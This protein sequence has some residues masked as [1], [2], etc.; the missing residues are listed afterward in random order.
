MTLDEN[1]PPKAE[2]LLSQVEL[3]PTDPPQAE[4]VGILWVLFLPCLLKMSLLAM[5]RM[6]TQFQKDTPLLCGGE[7]HLKIMKFSKISLGVCR[8]LSVINIISNNVY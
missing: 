1:N 3:I 5:R 8:D 4:R 2:Q 6:K 7:L